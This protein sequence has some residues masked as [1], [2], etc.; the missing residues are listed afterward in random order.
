MTT[1]LP[2]YTYPQEQ[3]RK[4]SISK[5]DITDT[6]RI[7]KEFHIPVPKAFQSAFQ[8]NDYNGLISNFSHY[9]DLEIYRRS[10]IINQLTLLQQEESLQD[11]F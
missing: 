5:K 10:Y 3:A 2:V 9:S 1:I 11:K 8:S 7:F 4:N 6:I